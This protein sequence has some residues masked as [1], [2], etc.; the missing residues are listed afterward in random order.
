[1]HSVPG[2]EDPKIALY[3]K[4]CLGAVDAA[5][6]P[7][8][9][10]SHQHHCDRTI[11]LAGDAAKCPALGCRSAE[12]TMQLPCLIC[13]CQ[14]QVLITAPAVVLNAGAVGFEGGRVLLLLLCVHGTVALVV[15]AAGCLPSHLPGWA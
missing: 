13:T 10:F 15:T 6:C 12:Y 14:L 5:V 4:S 2:G 3:S 8:L 11:C 9:P 1:M 7:S